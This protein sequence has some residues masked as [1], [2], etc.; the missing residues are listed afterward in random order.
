MAAALS[1]REEYCKEMTAWVCLYDKQK[2]D[3]L[4]QENTLRLQFCFSNQGLTLIQ[5][6]FLC[7]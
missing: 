7:S 1:K 4:Q 2:G 6:L 3:A 5:I